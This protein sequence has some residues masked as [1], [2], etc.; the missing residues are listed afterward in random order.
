M[1][2]LL[3]HGPYKG[4]LYPL[5]PS[6]SKFWKLVFS[7]IKLSV[8]R[9]HSHLGHPSQKIVHRVI[10]TNKLPC[11]RITSSSES[12][13]DV[14]LAPRHTNYLIQ[15]HRVSLRPPSNLFF[16]MSGGMLLIVLVTR[17]IM[18]A[19]LMIIV[20]LHGSTCFIT[21]LKSLSTSLN[22]RLLLNDSLIEKPLRFSPTG[23]G[24]MRN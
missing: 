3:L 10:S 20:N 8:D 17:N 14:V 7:A 6:T 15:C 4:G 24:N 19:S 9:W 21:N 12:I 18:L 5:P 11:S 22:F 13:C 16:R 1:R 23:V 2:K